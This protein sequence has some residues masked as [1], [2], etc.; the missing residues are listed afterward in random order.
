MWILYFLVKRKKVKIFHID[1][2]P[3]GVD[4]LTQESLEFKNS[5]FQKVNYNSI[6]SSN[7]KKFKCLNGFQETKDC[8]TCITASDQYLL[9]G[10]ESCALQKYSLPQVALIERKML[11]SKPY[12]L[13]LNSNS[14]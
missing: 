11:P 12:K 1:D 2:T 9:I 6:S 14:K 5:S 8:I 10:R 13:A 4:E 3:S 7:T